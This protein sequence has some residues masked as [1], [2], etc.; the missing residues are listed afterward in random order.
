[1]SERFSYEKA[2]VNIDL[3]DATKR[4]MAKSMETTDPCVLNRFGAFAS[5]YDAEFPGHE[6]PVLVT[7]T[8]EPGSKQKIALEH[9]H[10]RSI[11]YDLV[12]HL[13]NDIIVMGAKPLA[14]QDAIICGKLDKKVVSELVRRIAEACREQGCSLTGGETS[15]QPGVVEPGVYI[16][17]A[18][19]V[20]VVEK[21]K[22]LDGGRIAEGDAVVAIASN[23]LHTNGYSLVRAIMTARPEIL[24]WKVEGESFIETILRPHTCYHLAL[25]GL[26]G[27]AELHGLAHITGGGIQDNL[28]R[29]LPEKLDAAIDLGAIRIL[30]VFKLLRDMGSLA[31]G[32]MLRTFNMGVGMTAVVSDSAVERVRKHLAD[33]GCESYVIGQIVP[34]GK[35]VVYS[36]KLNW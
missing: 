16:L 9:G 17:V 3:S 30:P 2:G 12:N 6:H 29:I 11:C 1:M 35:K 20:G 15:V 14:V 25:E 26:L 32:E 24:N 33:H 28:D 13:V 18:S 19:I 8:E 36:G 10:T 22:I 21:S 31:D 4:A 7:K 5:L 27:S 23:G 34:G